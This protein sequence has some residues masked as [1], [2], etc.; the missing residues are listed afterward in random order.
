MADAK[1]G[2]TA[3]AERPI[4][5]HLQIWRWTLPMTLS[6]LHRLT[7]MGMALGALILAWWLVAVATGPEAYE[8]VQSF[9]AAPFGQFIL[10]GFSLAL[11]FHALNGVRH[12]F[13][14]VGFGFTIR[15]AHLSGWL[16]VLLTIALTVGAWSFGLSQAGATP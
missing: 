6:I 14:D 7:G 12:L 2:G 13:W 16:V 1:S 4:S 15:N 3:G 5:P 11:V 10:F 8:R 9:L